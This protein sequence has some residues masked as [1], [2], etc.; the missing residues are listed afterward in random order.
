MLLGGKFRDR[1][2]A[3]LKSRH[4]NVRRSERFAS[5]GELKYFFVFLPGGK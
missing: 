2:P 3:A 4:T 5:R 1:G